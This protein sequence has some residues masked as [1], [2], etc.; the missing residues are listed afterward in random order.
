METIIGLD[1]SI[2]IYLLEKHP[3]FFRVSKRL[4]KRI[5]NGQIQGVF[6]SIGLIEILTGPKQTGKFDLAI[7]YRELITT[8]PHLTIVGMNERI[9]DIAS[10]LRAKYKIHTP[11][12]IHLATA[13]D[14]RAKTFIT[15]DK[16]LK[17]VKEIRVRLLQ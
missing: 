13:I 12:A 4:L 3:T 14:A 9:V 1:T 2:F 16:T 6:S 10:D 8:F 17:R 5:E 11:D 15:N 7:E